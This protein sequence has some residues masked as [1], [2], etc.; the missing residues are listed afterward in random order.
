M[1]YFE[2]CDLPVLFWVIVVDC[3]SLDLY[4]IFSRESGHAWRIVGAHHLFG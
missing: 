3:E 1:R 4:V 2:M